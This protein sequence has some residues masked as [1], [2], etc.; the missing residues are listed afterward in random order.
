MRTLNLI[1]TLLFVLFA[2]AQINDPDPLLW[3]GY[4]LLVALVSALAFKSIYPAYLILAGGLVSVIGIG[5]LLPEF[6]RWLQMGAP[7]IVEEMQA[8]APHIE[9]TR[10]FLGLFL[11]L[12]VFIFHY[13]RARKI[14]TTH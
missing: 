2:I 11:G 14:K 7:T 5:L 1:L 9:F 10:E 3:M 13:F 4:Y 12:L 8:E 6:I